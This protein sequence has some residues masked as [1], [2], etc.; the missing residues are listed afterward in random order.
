MSAIQAGAY[1]G[2]VRAGKRYIQHV[3]ALPGSMDLNS[4]RVVSNVLKTARVL[5]REGLLELGQVVLLL[6][7]DMLRQVAEQGYDRGV[8]VGV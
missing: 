1:F 4:A 6:F 7:L 2:A 8:E 5:S 3:V